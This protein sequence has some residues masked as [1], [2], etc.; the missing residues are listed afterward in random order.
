MV[1]L[2]GAADDGGDATTEVLDCYYNLKKCRVIRF[3][4]FSACSFSRKPKVFIEMS[5][6]E[7]TPNRI[8]TLIVFY[9]FH[10]GKTAA[11]LPEKLHVF[12]AEPTG[13]F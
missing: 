1:L 8:I 7:G 11:V 4:L 5:L 13:L 2:R 12:F 6:R 10:I 3:P 9:G